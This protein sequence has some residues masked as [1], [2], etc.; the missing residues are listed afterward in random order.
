MIRNPDENADW[1]AVNDAARMLGLSHADLRELVEC[2]RLPSLRSLDGSLRFRR[3]DVQ[4]LVEMSLRGDF[5]ECL[6]AALL[7]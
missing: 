4:R 6:E 5:D 7:R 1:L 3:S 2:E